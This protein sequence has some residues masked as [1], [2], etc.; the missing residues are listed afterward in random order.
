MRGLEGNAAFLLPDI[1]DGILVHTGDWGVSNLSAMPN[2]AGCLHAEPA[3][4]ER[5]ADELVARN[6]TIRKNP[7]S[8]ADYPYAP[9]GVAVFEELDDFVT[10]GPS[11]P[12]TRA[13]YPLF[14]QCDDQW[15]D[16]VM[17]D[18]N[19]TICAVG[20]LMNT[21]LVTVSVAVAAALAVAAVVS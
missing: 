4:I 21:R 9:Q 2:S 12:R 18:N 15:G 6:V 20:C 13:A 1:R 19:L 14:K 10:A 16:T 8:G 3:A 5:I 7:G 11:A 17:G